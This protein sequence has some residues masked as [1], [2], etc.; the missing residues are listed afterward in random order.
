MP[1]VFQAMRELG[2]KK[3]MRELLHM[4]VSKSTKLLSLLAMHNNKAIMS[5]LRAQILSYTNEAM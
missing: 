3:A 5:N 4:L 2:S 1:L